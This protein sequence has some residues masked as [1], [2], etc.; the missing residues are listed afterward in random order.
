[1]APIQLR[2]RRYEP[3]RESKSHNLGI[4]WVDHE[5]GL[6]DAEIEYIAAAL[7]PFSLYEILEVYPGRGLELFDLFTTEKVSI[8][9]HSAASAFQKRMII[10]ASLIQVGRIRS[11]SG[12]APFT[13]MSSAK[14]IV[15][16]FR[17]EMMKELEVERLQD[18]HL[19]DCDEVIRS[20]Y[21]GL[22]LDSS[23]HSLFFQELLQIVASQPTRFSSWTYYWRL[24]G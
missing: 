3:Q 8:T 13:L 20:L 5:S 23:R 9:E 19:G 15:L 18:S 24:F 11:S 12:I 17:E 2:I 1:V 14:E 16:E 21:F 6:S 4:V 10:Y 7:A 22:L